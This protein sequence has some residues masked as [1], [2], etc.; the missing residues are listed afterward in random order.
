[1]KDMCF[2]IVPPCD[3]FATGSI[4]IIPAKVNQHFKCFYEPLFE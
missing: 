2:I 1:M 3:G 4:G